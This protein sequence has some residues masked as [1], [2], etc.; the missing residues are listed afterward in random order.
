MFFDAVRTGTKTNGYQNEG[1]RRAKDALL[2]TALASVAERRV[3][4]FSAFMIMITNMIM[5]MIVMIIMVIMIIMI[6][7]IIM[8]MIM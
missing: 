7:M 4:D 6:T 8:I 3:D 2:F 1:E 5:T